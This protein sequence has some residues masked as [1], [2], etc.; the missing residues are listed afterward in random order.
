MDLVLINS[1]FLEYFFLLVHS[2]SG[3]LYL[4]PSE[5]PLSI[6]F[7]KCCFSGQTDTRL[8]QKYSSEPQKK[9][10]FR[11]FNFN[12]LQQFYYCK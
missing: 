2:N 10:N 4:F 1:S 9:N 11:Q 6:F 8:T 12:I 5:T 3:I 7:L